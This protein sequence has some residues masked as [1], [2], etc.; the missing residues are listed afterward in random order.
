MTR[1]RNRGRAVALAALALVLGSPGAGNA[2][3][4]DQIDELWS[5]MFQALTADTAQAEALLDR[6]VEL[7]RAVPTRDDLRLAQALRFQ[8]AFRDN[9]DDHA[10]AEPPLLE[11][12]ALYAKHLGPLN[13]Y[14]G[15]ILSSLARVYTTRGDSWRAA[16]AMDR[17]TAVLPPASL[18]AAMRCARVYLAAGEEA[19]ALLCL[20]VAVRIDPRHPM[21]L[22]DLAW[23]LLTMSGTSRADWE[24]AERLARSGLE[25][26]PGAPPIIDTLGFAM[27]RLERADDALAILDP[28]LDRERAAPTPALAFF[29]YHAALAHE[30]AGNP[31]QSAELARAA[32]EH[33]GPR[34]ERAKVERLLARLT[35]HLPE[36]SGRLADVR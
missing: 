20:E 12:R 6:I 28:A 4:L 11:A 8:G 15:V 3:D 19:R 33:A 16:V 32:L 22:N 2:V 17:A 25:I 18:A 24:R 21:A 13:P 30:L 5:Q 23:T 27:V 34:F 1:R 31:V 26:A 29:E 10:G 36:H 9:R 7:E 14:A 35:P